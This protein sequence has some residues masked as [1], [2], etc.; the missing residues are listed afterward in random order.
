MAKTAK[1]KPAKKKSPNKKPAALHD[2][3][4]PNEDAGYRSA[5]NAL[6]KAE[7]GLRRE[8]ERVAALRRKLPA[9]GTIREDY[10]FE[11]MSADG[12]TRRVKLSEL[13]GD[14]PALVVYSFMYGPKMEK[15]CP[16]CTSILD[17]M[18]G[19]TRHVSQRASF[20]VIAKSPIERIRAFA[21]DR[22]WRGLRLLS[23]AKN[24]FNRDY[25]AESSDGAQWPMLNVFA[26]KG[27][28]IHHFYGTELLF[29]PREASQ[30]HRHVDMI[31]PLW[32]ALDYTPEG[33]GTDWYPKLDYGA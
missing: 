29:G 19:Q 24:D 5:R 32:N 20:V 15:A 22:G 2:K 7:M 21:R 13:F 11:E 1:K 16:S 28:K 17:A 10:V 4:F 8:I 31:W 27:G 6:L 18:N 33:R 3:R 25:F 26:K 14:K 12:Q 30:D 23:S 9:G